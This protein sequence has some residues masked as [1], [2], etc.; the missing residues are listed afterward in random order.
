M[1]KL[2]IRMFSKETKELDEDFTTN[3]VYESLSQVLNAI[4]RLDK[5]FVKNHWYF[6]YTIEEV[7]NG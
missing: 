6:S 4:R 5:K 7:Y 2:T 1:Y 3:I